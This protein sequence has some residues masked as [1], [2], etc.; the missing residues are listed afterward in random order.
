MLFPTFLRRLPIL[1]T[2]LALAGCCASDI[3][4]CRDELADAL[5]F[6]INY[7]RKRQ[8]DNNSR[9]AISFNAS[10]IDTIRIYRRNKL[11]ASLV[12]KDKDTTGFVRQTDVVTVVRQLDTSTFPGDTI[13]KSE[14]PYT[15][16]NG[17][18]TTL[19]EQ[20]LIVINNASPFTSS[21]STKLNA[22][23]YRIEVV[24]N[25]SGNRRPLATYYITGIDLKGRYNGDGC[26]TCYE[27]TA[28]TDT[29]TIGIT[30]NTPKRVFPINAYVPDSANQ[31]RVVRL[32]FPY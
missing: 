12:G 19:K 5:F 14:V 32:R 8:Y 2:C 17:Y 18:T 7:T 25:S 24:K 29:L 20:E 23:T 26:C 13:I 3:C 11:P 6:R 1:A 21:G 22:Y 15:S 4:T 16:T 9:R 30:A 27:N 31:R 10:D 28:K